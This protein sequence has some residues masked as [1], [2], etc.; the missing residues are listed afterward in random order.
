MP[1]S[2][3]PLFLVVG[4]A[5]TFPWKFPTRS[6]GNDAF[7]E[8]IMSRS[9]I[10]RVCVELCM[11]GLGGEACGDDCVDL[12]PLTVTFQSDPAGDAVR[13]RS[14]PVG[15][16]RSDSCPVLCANGLGYP[17]CSCRNSKSK[18]ANFVQVC[19]HFCLSYD[20]QVFGCQPCDVYRNLQKVKD[21]SY[22]LPSNVSSGYLMVGMVHEMSPYWI[23]WC[24]DKCSEGEGG[25][26]CNCDKPIMATMTK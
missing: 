7:F 16:P 20:Y 25:S 26:A 18:P 13:N 12:S 14:V 2:I 19:G 17:L 9:E 1:I 22:L 23:Q 3:F 10:K 6:H 11:S 8:P 5:W 15:S 4:V 21:M 24:I